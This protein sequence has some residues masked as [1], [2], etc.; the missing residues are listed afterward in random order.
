MYGVVVTTQTRTA[1]R[2][3]GT[4]SEQEDVLMPEVLAAGTQLPVQVPQALGAGFVHLPAV[5][6]EE[7]DPFA[8]RLDVDVAWYP[9][10]AADV[11]EQ[12]PHLPRTSEQ[13]GHFL[14]PQVLEYVEGHHHVERVGERRLERRKVAPRMLAEVLQIEST[15]SFR[16]IPAR[17]EEAAVVHPVD[18]DAGPAAIVEEPSPGFVVGEQG[19]E[20][21]RELVP[22]LE[23]ARVEKTRVVVHRKKRAQPAAQPTQHRSPSTC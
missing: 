8:V 21:R 15:G 17:V 14:V 7:V 1:T 22:V 11:G 18:H 10:L 23:P 6:C 12:A 5:P 3:A 13:L 9:G 20:H 4:R 2:L 16:R 19:T